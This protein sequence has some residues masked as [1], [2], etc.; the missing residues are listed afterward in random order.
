MPPARKRRNGSSLKV[1]LGAFKKPQKRPFIVFS[2]GRLGRSEF[3][4]F[5][6]FGSAGR[7]DV[8]VEA[9][10]TNT[11][12]NLRTPRT[13]NANMAAKKRTTRLS[14]EKLE[15]REVM[16]GNVTAGI[17][18]NALDLTGDSAANEVRV[19]KLSSGAFF[20]TGLNGTKINGKTS[21]TAVASEDDLRVNLGG[22]N[23]RLYLNSPTTS[24]TLTI[25]Y[26]S[27]NM[28]SGKDLVEINNL[29]TIDTIDTVFTLG[30]ST[31]SSTDSDVFRMNGKNSFAQGLII[32]TG[33]GGDSVELNNG[34]VG[35]KLTVDLGSGDDRIELCDMFFADSDINGGSGNDFWVRI[36]GK[37]IKYRNM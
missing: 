24:K 27:V 14:C 25:D 10:H 16:A 18:N 13:R 4:P 20:V 33:S 12:Q 26:L 21:Y 29:K 6:L 36:G 28:G 8:G 7:S 3:F 31:D 19:E 23:D 5:S 17:V 34:T 2:P 22:G 1:R 15:T 32:S 30:S 37:G 35:K 11:R 9:I